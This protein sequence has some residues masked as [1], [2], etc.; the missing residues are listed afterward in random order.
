LRILFVLQ[1][2]GLYKGISSP[3]VGVA[4]VNA[5]IFGV[6]GSL[7]PYV[8]GQPGNDA[9]WAHFVAGSISGGVQ[10]FIASPMEL[11]KTR[12]QLNEGTGGVATKAP[13]FVQVAKNIYHKE[14]GFRK[15]IYKGFGVTVAREI[16][17]FGFYFAT[18]EALTSKSKLMIKK[19]RVKVVIY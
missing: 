14:G 15:G 1:F 11:V 16:P 9:L 13:S 8:H 6:Y 4:G 19:M 5:L 2:S 3:L 7:R 12:M 18:Y 17:G 10:S